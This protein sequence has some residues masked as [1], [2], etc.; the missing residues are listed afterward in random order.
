[1][2]AMSRYSA[3]LALLL[4]LSSG[5]ACDCDSQP[6]ADAGPEEIE[7]GTGGLN[8]EPLED[9]Q[10]L[11]LV[12][13]IQGGYHFVVNARIRG[14]LS[15]DPS[16]P[17]ALG[18]PQTRFTIFDED[19]RQIDNMPRPYRLG[20]REIEDGWFELP[21][22]RI[23]QIDQ[24]LVIDEGLVPAIYTQR[25][26]LTVEIRD[27]RGTEASAELWVVPEQD[28]SPDAGLFQPDAGPDAAP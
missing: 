1:M 24:Q 28:I 20:Y 4:A 23:L 7:L 6:K 11:L 15:G 26:R 9:D 21:S 12:A 5:Q 13:G 14:L 2:Q 3:V 17:D 10:P 19:G 22:G 25:V 8:F 27:A 18:N 16:V